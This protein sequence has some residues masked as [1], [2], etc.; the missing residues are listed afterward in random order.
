MPLTMRS[1]KNE[2]DSALMLIAL[3]KSLGGGWRAASSEIAGSQHD[4]G[5][6]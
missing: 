1:L 2:R 5:A 3:Y 4:S 6:Q